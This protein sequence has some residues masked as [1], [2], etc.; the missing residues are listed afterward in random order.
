MVNKLFRLTQPRPGQA[1][2]GRDSGVGGRVGAR[3]GR[4]WE[5]WGGGGRV[6]LGGG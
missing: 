4:R 3:G 1:K 6:G 2:R 5:G